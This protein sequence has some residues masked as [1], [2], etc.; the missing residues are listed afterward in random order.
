MRWLVNRHHAQRKI[1][2]ENPA[3][4][5]RN[6]ILVVAGDARLKIN[7]RARHST[8]IYVGAIESEKSRESSLNPRALADDELIN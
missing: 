4:R 2:G 3:S 6:R 7:R 8:T 1:S 5:N